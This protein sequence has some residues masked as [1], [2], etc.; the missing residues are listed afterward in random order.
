MNLASLK[1]HNLEKLSCESGLSQ[2][3][4]VD[5]QSHN[6]ST[7]R[8]TSSIL[9]ESQE[10]VLERLDS[11]FCCISSMDMWRNKL[12]FNSIFSESFFEVVCHVC[13]SAA[14]SADGGHAA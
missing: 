8:Q 1:A 3:S 4:Y 9:T 13:L 2:L 14:L 12:V 5:Y 11:T 7:R 6:R 10:M